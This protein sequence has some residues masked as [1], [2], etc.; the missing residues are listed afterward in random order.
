MHS[1]ALPIAAAPTSASM[2][3]RRLK[4]AALGDEHDALVAR[5][6]P[7]LSRRVLTALGARDVLHVR[8]DGRLVAAA[9]I[10]SAQMWGKP[11]GEFVDGSRPVRLALRTLRLAD[12]RLAL[13]LRVCGEP[14]LGGAHG[15]V[16]APDATAADR[17]ALAEA[18]RADAAAHGARGVLVKELVGPL[19]GLGQALCQADFCHFQA[20]PAMVL[21]LDPAWRS[22]EDLKA[23]FISK[24]RVKVN[25]AD[26]LSAP[27]RRAPL[28]A[29]SVAA[30]LPQLQ[31]LYAQ[32]LDRADAALGRFDLARL[33]ALL[34]AAPDVVQAHGYWLGDRLVAFSTAV[35]AAQTLSAHLVGLDYG[36]NAEL[37]LYPRMLNDFV[38]DA[39][40]RGAQ[41]VDFGRTAEEIKSTLG[42][43][44]VPQP[45]CLRFV[46]P[47]A[48]RLLPLLGRAV[49]LPAPPQRWPFQRTWYAAR[50]A[51]LAD[52]LGHAPEGLPG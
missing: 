51:W 15:L 47:A 13:P 50:G 25:R 16:L 7:W 24:Y 5:H 14:T 31:A 28:D 4:P 32:V 2:V 12:R 6:S 36:C 48:N 39:F 38:R 33:P 45:M 35:C 46:N 11:L 52:T 27:L 23:S 30:H 19:S 29:V 41:R 43:V 40:A 18:L 1:I 37:A 8:R 34:T 26:T 49:D 22:F 42:A 44:P 17:K 20:G 21:A 10:S 3:V 9:A